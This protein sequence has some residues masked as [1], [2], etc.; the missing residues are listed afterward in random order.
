MAAFGRTVSKLRLEA[1]HFAWKEEGK[2]Q[3]PRPLQMRFM[4]AGLSMVQS[5]ALQVGSRLCLKAVC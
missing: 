2:I 1:L 4:T 3:N 5:F